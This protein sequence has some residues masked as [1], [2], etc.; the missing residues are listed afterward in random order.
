MNATAWYQGNSPERRIKPNFEKDVI[1]AARKVMIKARQSPVDF[2][3]FYVDRSVL[4]EL[5]TA[6]RRHDDNILGKKIKIEEPPRTTEREINWRVIVEFVCLYTVAV[7][8]SLMV[9]KVLGKL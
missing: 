5:F 6:I 2:E 3:L 9:L 4:Q 8:I 7:A 1:R